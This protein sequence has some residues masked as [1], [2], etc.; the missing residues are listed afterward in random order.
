[1]LW[2]VREL[3]YDRLARDAG[4]CLSESRSGAEKDQD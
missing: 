4:L 1:M 3:R 2:M